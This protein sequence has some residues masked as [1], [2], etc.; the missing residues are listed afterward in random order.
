[1]L[2][3][4]RL[5]LKNAVLQ[6]VIGTFAGLLLFCALGFALA[7]FYMWLSTIYV[8]HIS[9]LIVAGVLLLFALFGL[10]VARARAKRMQSM[11]SVATSVPPE[12]GAAAAYPGMAP[13]YGPLLSA[14]DQSMRSS[15][16]RVLAIALAAGLGA[17]FLSKRRR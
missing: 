17:G 9:A 13:V 5:Q 11:A 6:A 4:L 16:M 14:F 2:N 7:A 8:P 12:A 1:M 10:L 15:P 3:F